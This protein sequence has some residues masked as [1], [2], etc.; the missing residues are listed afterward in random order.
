MKVTKVRRLNASEEKF[1]PEVPNSKD[2]LDLSLWH[3]YMW[4]IP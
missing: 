3:M 2:A 1:R 4:H